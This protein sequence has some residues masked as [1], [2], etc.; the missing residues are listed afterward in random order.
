MTQQQLITALEPMID[1][2]TVSDVLL[3]I[4]RV[5]NE[6]AEHIRINWQDS[7]TAAAW[8][9]LATRCDKLAATTAL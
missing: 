6:K 7:I 4:G 9:R 5:C 8:D 3:A 1:S 2:A